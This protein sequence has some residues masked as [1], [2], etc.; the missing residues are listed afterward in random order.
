MSADTA[1][2]CCELACVLT[3]S[4][5]DGRTLTVPR[6]ALAAA[7]PVLREA[8]SLPLATPGVLLLPDDDPEAWQ[9]TL[10]L[11][12]PCGFAPDIISWVGGQWPAD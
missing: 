3:L 4:L 11:L 8:L 9:A 1:A 2:C 6:Y 12:V 5:R 7:S 10:R